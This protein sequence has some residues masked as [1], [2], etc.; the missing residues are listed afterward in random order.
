MEKIKSFQ[1]NHNLLE[2]GFYVSREDYNIITY[3]FRTRKPN[4]GDYM[5]GV[6]AIIRASNYNEEVIRQCVTEAQEN[7]YI[8]EVEVYE[9][10]EVSAK[11]YAKV[12]LNYKYHFPFMQSFSWKKKVRII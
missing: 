6:S 9:S 7:G 12:S 5:E 11:K 3:D 2:P 10:P 8:L 4:A 1:I